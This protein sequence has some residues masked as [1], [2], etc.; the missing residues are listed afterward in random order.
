MKMFEIKIKNKM[1]TERYSSII[2]KKIVFAYLMYSNSL[3][4]NKKYLN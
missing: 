1:C 2:K 4:T 3:E